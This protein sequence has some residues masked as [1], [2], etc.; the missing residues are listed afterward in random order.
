MKFLK[1]LRTSFFTEHIG[2]CFWELVFVVTQNISSEVRL[3][4]ECTKLGA[5]LAFVLYVP[6][7]FTRSLA[8][9]VC[10]PS[11][12]W[13][14]RAFIF[15]CVMRAFRFLRAL[16]FIKCLTCLKCF[17]CFILYMPYL[18]SIFYVP[19]F[20]CACILLMYMLIKLTQINELNYDFSSLLLL[21]S[22]I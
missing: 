12:I 3:Y 20:L 21:N 11:C 19:S 4:R 8:L 14:V 10:V 1:F 5:F 9:R 18:P 17:T 13:F 15:L 6:T 2:G 16:I 7:C 22:V